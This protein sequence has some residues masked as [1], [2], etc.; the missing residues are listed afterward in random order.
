MDNTEFINQIKNYQNYLQAL[1]EVK[2]ELDK[3]LKEK[4][5]ECDKLTKSLSQ[6][7]E[8]SIN[9]LENIMLRVSYQI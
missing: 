1:E 5:T 9:A 7:G 8:Q 2:D 6:I 3:N 4:N